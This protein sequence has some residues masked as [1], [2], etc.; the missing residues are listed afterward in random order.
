[1]GV[2]LDAND[3]AFRCNLV[4]LGPG[5]DPLMEDFTAGHIQSGESATIIE[6]LQACLG[7]DIFRFYPGVGYRHLLV[8]RGGSDALF[9]TPPH[10]ITGKSTNA[11]LPQGTGAASLLRLM[12]RA[13]HVLRDHQVNRLRSERGQRPANAIWPWG[14]GR[15]PR[16]EKMTDR[17]GLRGGMISAVDLLNGIGVY[18]GLDVIPVAG[19]TGYIDTDYAGKARAALASLNQRDF[20]FVHVEAPDEMGH[21]GNLARKIQAIEDFDEKVV[22]TV[23]EGIASLGQVRVLVLSDHPTPIVLRTHAA[24]PSP[25]AVWSSVPGENLRTGSSYNEVA[26]RTTGVLVRPGHRLMDLFLAHWRE[27]LE[28]HQ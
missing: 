17:Y 6:T 9:T 25:F 24:D 28:E 23:L 4:Y 26:A 2:P 16:M 11:F 3:M 18:A 22:G 5:N 13:R 15:A 8:W 7:D 20:V 19:A 21:E 14:Q 27:I 12:E 10:D 1:M